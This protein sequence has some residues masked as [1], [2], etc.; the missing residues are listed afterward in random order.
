[1]SRTKIK[2]SIDKTEKQMRQQ[3]RQL[4]SWKAGQK[5]FKL[6]HREKCKTKNKS[7]RNVLSSK[8]V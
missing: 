1:M 6:K 2:N 7:V 8:K 4:I 3:K 5:F